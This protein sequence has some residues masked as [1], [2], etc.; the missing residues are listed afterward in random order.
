M[1]L[2]EELFSV[3]QGVRTGMNSA[4]LIT[5]QELAELPASE[6]KWFRPASVSESIQ[7]GILR[8]NHHI[9]YPYN[10]RGLLIRDE[11]ELDSE[12]PVYS[13]RYLRPNRGRLSQRPS[14]RSSRTDWWGLSERRSW[15]L[16]PKPRIVSKYFGGPGKFRG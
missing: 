5:T 16:D 13:Q 14:L 9:F 2:I 15:A 7:D 10:E 12:V 8:S 4:F 11:H 3:R 6:R 1:V